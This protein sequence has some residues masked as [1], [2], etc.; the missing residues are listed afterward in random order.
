MVGNGTVAYVALLAQFSTSK[1]FCSAVSIVPGNLRWGEDKALFLR[2]RESDEAEVAPSPN[3]RR[4]NQVV[5]AFREKTYLGLKARSNVDKIN[6]QT[7]ISPSD[8]TLTLVTYMKSPSF[9][10]KRF[11]VSWY[12][13]IDTLI[14]ARHINNHDVT[15]FGEKCLA[16]S[17]EE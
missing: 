8:N 3:R 10:D 2:L 15:V 11:T 1:R 5:E 17:W 12:C 14:F 13:S 9:R 7:L 16:Q 4:V 6:F